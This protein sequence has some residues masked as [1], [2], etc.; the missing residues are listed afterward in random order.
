[1]T[2]SSMTITK[3][4]VIIAKKLNLSRIAQKYHEIFVQFKAKIS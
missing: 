4:Q 2:Y 3:R 1:M